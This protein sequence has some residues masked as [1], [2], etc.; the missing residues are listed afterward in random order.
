VTVKTFCKSVYICRSYGRKSSV[1]FFDS[2]INLLK[3]KILAKF[4]RG[5]S[6][7]GRQIE[8]GQVQIGDFRQISRHSSEMVQASDIV[9]MEIPCA[10]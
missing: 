2:H 5:Y 3:P 7:R 8:V 10:L 9:T 1:L 4:Q 6:K